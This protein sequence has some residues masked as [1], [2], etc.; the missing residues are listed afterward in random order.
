MLLDFFIALQLSV[1][2]MISRLQALDKAVHKY[3]SLLLLRVRHYR[4]YVWTVSYDIDRALILRRLSL[5]QLTL[6]IVPL[7]QLVL[8]YI[9]FAFEF[10]IHAKC[11]VQVVEIHFR[12][13]D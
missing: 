11:I 4:F 12:R 7:E 3:R 1:Q 10:C 5:M 6:L 8:Q 2:L 9:D 13:D